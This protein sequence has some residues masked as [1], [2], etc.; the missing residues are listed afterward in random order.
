[1]HHIKIKKIP[2]VDQKLV[3]LSS[4]FHLKSA[5]SDLMVMLVKNPFFPHLT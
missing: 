3:L 4:F 2:V 5:Y 1:M